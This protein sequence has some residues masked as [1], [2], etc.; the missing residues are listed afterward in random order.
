MTT[1]LVFFWV[2]MA[3]LMAGA[4]AVDKYGKKHKNDWHFG[5]IS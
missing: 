5:F 2:G 1:V 4:I 3:A